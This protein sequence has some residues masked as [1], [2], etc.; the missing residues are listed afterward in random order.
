MQKE[1]RRYDLDVVLTASFSDPLSLSG[2]VTPHRSADTPAPVAPTA[3][4]VHVVA[5]PSASPSASSSSSPRDDKRSARKER[6]D[7]KHKK[8]K[9]D[10]LV[11]VESKEKDRSE[12]IEKEPS[13]RIDRVQIQ[14]PK[15]S[16][17]KS[18]E[19]ETEKSPPSLRKDKSAS[20]VSQADE[21]TGSNSSGTSSRQF[22]DRPEAPSHLKVPRLTR[23]CIRAFRDGAHSK[24]KLANHH[25]RLIANL[26]YREDST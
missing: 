17:G 2:L 12:K 9:Q 14:D 6:E 25:S 1:V 5:L 7:K 15:L 18:K 26:P 19:K 3:L 21:R 22:L 8:E 4:P 13:Q 11:K 16:D 23:L 20:D 10:R 24:I